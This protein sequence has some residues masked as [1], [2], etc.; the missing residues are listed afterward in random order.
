MIT[1]YGIR[2]PFV[3]RIRAALTQKGLDFQHVNV[4]MANRSEE[5]QKLTAIGKIPVLEDGDGTVVWDSAH[6]VDYLDAKYPDTYP[7]MG[8]NPKERATVL[9]VVALLNSAYELLIPI[10]M[11]KYGVIEKMREAGMSHRA[12]VYDDKAKEDARKDVARRLA[13]LKAMLGENKFFT[14]Q[15]S[16]ADA[17]ALAALSSFQKMGE[18]IGEW[19]SWVKDLLSDEKIAKLFPPENEKG[20]RSI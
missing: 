15:Y 12:V 3:F 6:V 16:L 5:F 13:S 17:S 8:R 11:E 20:V 2:S 7:M 18:E 10:I 14:G 4:D 1:I 19:D 9:N